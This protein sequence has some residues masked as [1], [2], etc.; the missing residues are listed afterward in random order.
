MIKKQKRML[1]K[2]YFKD[3]IYKLKLE[4]N[5]RVMG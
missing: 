2:K 4:Y 1:K 5:R 3:A